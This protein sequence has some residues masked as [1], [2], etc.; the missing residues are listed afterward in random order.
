MR[1]TKWASYANDLTN[2]LHDSFIIRDYI[3]EEFEALFSS[4]PDYQ[5][6]VKLLDYLNSNCSEMQ[7]FVTASVIRSRLLK[8]PQ[9]RPELG[10]PSSFLLLLWN[11]VWI[12]VGEGKLMKPGEVYLL[13]QP[14]D[15]LRRYVP[16]IDTSLISLRKDSP[17]I[18]TLGIRQEIPSRILFNLL[19]KWSCDL[20]EESL[21]KLIQSTHTSEA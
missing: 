8:Q 3:C 12:P 14:Q 15:V 18:N 17:L 4:N 13:S 16:H 5:L 20:D 19:M 1:N 11:Q 10:L 21:N 7:N 9:P 2:R 6:C